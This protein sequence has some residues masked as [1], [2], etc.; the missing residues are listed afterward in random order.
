M[1]FALEDLQEPGDDDWESNMTN[2]RLVS[3]LG[4]FPR[5]V[6]E[7][8]EEEEGDLFISIKKNITIQNLISNMTT[9]V[10]L[11]NSCFSEQN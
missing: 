9:L 5:M 10:A 1:E 2:E 7:E 3:N 4:S 6:E 8:E 11:L